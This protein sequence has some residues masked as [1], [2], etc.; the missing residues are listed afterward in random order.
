[1]RQ[2]DRS[3]RD[4][5]NKPPKSLADEGGFSNDGLNL[6]TYSTLRR[7]LTNA[8]ERRGEAWNMTG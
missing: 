7:K 2:A 3:A 1:M 6:E 8:Q 4:R 5:L